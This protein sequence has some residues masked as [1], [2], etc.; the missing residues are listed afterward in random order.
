MNLKTSFNSF[1]DY[2]R[3]I[4]SLSD[5]VDYESASANIHKDV[6]FRGPNVFILFFAIMIASLG[7]NVNSIPV[8]IGAM[9]I[10]PLMGPIIGFGFSLGTNDIDLLKS[11]VKNLLV[12]VA[13]SILGATLFFLISPL[14][15]ENPTELLART[16]PT[17][18]DVLIALFGGFAGIIEISRK[19]KG[20]VMSGVAIATALM[21]PLCT[22]GFGI[23]NLNW[24]YA[25]GALYLFFINS[26][27]IALATFLTVKYL[28]YP[29]VSDADPMLARR[30]KHLIWIMI[31]IIVIP[32]ILSAITVIRDN[33]ISRN[34]TRLIT[35]HK[36][37]GKS[38]I[39]DYKFNSQV[40]PATIDIYMAGERLT[41]D[42]RLLFYK[43]AEALGF[44]Q[45][46]IR[47]HE[48]ASV[49]VTPF[50]QEQA[51]KD[52]FA[53]HEQQLEQRDQTIAQLQ[54]ELEEIEDRKIPIRQLDK[55]ICTQ[56]PSIKSVTVA[57]GEQVQGDS[58][59]H[60]III[61]PEYKNGST[62]ADEDRKRLTDWLA[63]R[64]NEDNILV[65]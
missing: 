17:I 62:L 63:V 18:Y 21:P 24:Q 29:S 23:A 60:L 61:K 19:D 41:D 12:M 8:I 3:S 56:Y 57:R 43:D 5:H 9:L 35:E 40:K 6:A 27:F 59:V 15:M 58:L 38:Y 50:N 39:F 31:T 20:T 52:I 34:A 1:I 33:N 55:E 64:L 47:F 16:N 25:V 46:Q 44:T 36:T 51:I 53:N 14:K 11:S 10:S 7:L 22:V 2:L 4:I 28:N 49:S 54:S 45:S 13:I 26:V 42:Q 48:D 37:I 30:R 32:S 65:L